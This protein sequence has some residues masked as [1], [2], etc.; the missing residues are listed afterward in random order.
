[1][2]SNLLKVFVAVAK[3]KSISL[4]GTN[5]WFYAIQRHTSHQT[6]GKNTGV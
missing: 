1:M 6:V 3:Q 4:A 2:D 5:S